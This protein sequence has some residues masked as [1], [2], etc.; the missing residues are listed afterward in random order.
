MSDLHGAMSAASVDCIWLLVRCSLQVFH[1]GDND[2]L[3]LQ[4]DFHIYC[5]NLFDTERAAQVDNPHSSHHFSIH[6]MKTRLIGLTCPKTLQY[7]VIRY[8]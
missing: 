7:T 1:G 3:W 4:R 6:A 2:V 8:C 5:A